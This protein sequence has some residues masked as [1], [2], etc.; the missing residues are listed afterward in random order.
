MIESILR[1]PI[2]GGDLHWLDDNALGRV[3][4][5]IAKGELTHADGSAVKLALTQAL[6]S[7]EFI[8]PVVDGIFVMLPALAISRG[9]RPID[10]DPQ[11]VMRF[12]D[13]V[14]WQQQNHTFNDTSLF[15]DTR[16]E[17]RRY[18]R[19]SYMRVMDYLP[20][21]GRY[22]LDAASGPIPYPEY[23][24]Y[25]EHYDKRVCV[26]FSI[27]ALR[28]AKKKLGPHGVYIQADVT[29]L[30]I[31]DGHMDAFVSLHTIYHVPAERQ[32]IAF[33]ELARVTAPA[34]RGVVVYSWP[35]SVA[36]EA[37]T[38]WIRPTYAAKAALKKALP[39]RL[40]DRLSRAPAHTP[41]SHQ[42]YFHPHDYAWFQR[43][44][45][46]DLAVWRFASGGF[47]ERYVRPG[48]AGRVITGAL[49]WLERAAPRACGRLGQYP[50]MVYG[51]LPSDRV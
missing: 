15:E 38:N 42:L 27:T 16:P 20:A 1:C 49:L 8:Y 5:Q 6:S 29:Q 39:Q 3:R 28:E 34:G 50:M 23:L 18:V 13:E 2:T 22:L 41:A 47:L 24:T 45:G 11:G 7:G 26:D 36:M 30:P 44:V 19:A 17:S 32:A 33:R 35:R 40:I 51:G 31:K 4:V 9:V 12:Y 25:S 48:A 43:E 46:W 37:L 10:S 21:S 14:G